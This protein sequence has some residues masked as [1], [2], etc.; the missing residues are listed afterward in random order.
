MSR[1]TMIEESGEQSLAESHPTEQSRTHPAWDVVSLA[2][3]TSR[4]EGIVRKMTNTLFR[5]ARTSVLNTA[6][7]FSCC[8]V[9]REHVLLVMAES[10]PIHMM[11]GPDLM[12]MSM[13]RFHPTLRRG[14]AFLHNSP[15]HGNSHAGDHCILVPVIDE[16][17]SHQAT[18]VVKAHLADI[19]NSEPTTMMATARDVYHEGALIF[20]CVKVQ[21]NHQNIEDIIRM[22][23]VRIRIP[24]DW[25][26]D[27]LGMLGAAR[28]GE[29]ELLAAGRE[30]GWDAFH[31]YTEDWFDYSEQRMRAAIRALPAGKVTKRNAHDPVPLLG[32]ENGVPL[33]VSVDVRP[34]EAVIEVDLRNNP[35]CVPCGINLTESTANTAAMIGIFNSIDHTIPRNGGSARCLNIL[36][37][38]NCC[39]GIPVHP[40]SCA[41][42][43]SGIAERIAGLVQVAMAELGDGLGMAETG[44][45]CPPAVAVLSGRDPRHGGAA[46]IDMMI[47]GNSAGAGHARGDGWLTNGEVGDGGMM[48][49][50]STEVIE[51]LHPIRI[52]NDQIL[53]DTEGAGRFRSAPSL[54]VEYGPVDTQ[55]EVM[56]APDGRVY[57]ALGARGGEPGGT[58]WPYK[59]TKAGELEELDNSGQVVLVPGETIVSISPAGGGYGPPIERD[60]E[61]VRHDVVEGWISRDR[62]AKV[63]GILFDAEG[64]VD[65]AASRARRSEIAARVAR[66]DESGAPGAPNELLPGPRPIGP[67]AQCVVNRGG[68]PGCRLE[69]RPK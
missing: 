65:L 2:V 40:A 69:E 15:Y 14:D 64:Q 39:A 38:E 6:R 45:E 61:R 62:A 48:M 57:G 67:L 18:V 60:P 46:F 51:L 21:Q 44:A 59:R 16:T 42:A 5:T 3:M 9:T 23:Q 63:Y 36:L 66:H 10:L 20:P 55:L 56:Y 37:R 24:E 31:R 25:Y 53:P 49:R 35:D 47:L 34:H 41:T 43:T 54:Y 50:D 26:G 19:G 12:C 68:E 58:L 28:I 22:C 29:R 52:W 4:L 8:I 17:G 30:F 32:V 11:S 7:D 13:A 1:Q 27:F 33:E